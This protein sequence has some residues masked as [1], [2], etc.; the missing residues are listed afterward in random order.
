MQQN[1][2]VS[3]ANTLAYLNLSQL[4]NE[5]SDMRCQHREEQEGT[6]QGGHFFPDNEAIELPNVCC[7][8][9]LVYSAVFSFKGGETEVLRTKEGR[10]WN[11]TVLSDLCNNN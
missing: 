8:T 5:A 4:H 3:V 7:N 11:P 2:P 9:D 6:T 10:A 1:R